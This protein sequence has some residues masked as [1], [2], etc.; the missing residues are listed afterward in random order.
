MCVLNHLLFVLTLLKCAS[1]KKSPTIPIL[2]I[3]VEIVS[4]W[5]SKPMKL[6][7][8]KIGVF[9]YLFLGCFLEQKSWK[10]LQNSFLSWEN[11]N[12]FLFFW[13]KLPKFPYYL[14]NKP[15]VRYP[16]K[17]KPFNKISKALHKVMHRGTSWR[18]SSMETLF[19]FLQFKGGWRGW[20]GVA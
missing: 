4:C 2:S 18:S 19:F 6:N 10:I 8:H 16:I 11:W 15:R 14:Q 9:I 1:G 7:D 20:V 17:L 3:V 12:L 5:N 13:K